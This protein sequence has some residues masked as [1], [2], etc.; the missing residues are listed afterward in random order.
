NAGT[1]AVRFQTPRRA[2]CPSSDFGPGP[3]HP[4]GRDRAFVSA[5]RLPL[6]SLAP[7]A[8]TRPARASRSLRSL[9]KQ[10][11]GPA[12]ASRSPRANSHSARRQR[13]EELIQL[14]E[15]LAHRIFRAVLRFESFLRRIELV[16]EDERLAI[17]L[18]EGH[19]R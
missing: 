5:H 11:P 14:R 17:A 16:D 4:P 6:A 10:R 2:G 9:P 1:R 8:E 13:P 18:L 15:G 7:K 12:R 3:S 19:R